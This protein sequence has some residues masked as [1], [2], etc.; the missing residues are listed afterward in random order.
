MWLI[1][2]LGNPGSKYLLTRHN[3]GFMA[4]DYLCQGAG[5]PSENGKVEHKAMTIDFKWDSEPVKLVKPQTYMNLSGESVSALLQYYKIPIEKL[6]VIHDDLDQPFGQIRIKSQSGD[7]GHNGLKSLIET[8]GTNNFLRVKI[9]IGRPQD[10]RFEIADYV[11]QKFSKTESE[12][13]PDVLNE[14][15]DAIECVIF[16]GPINAMNRFNV[17]KKE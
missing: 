6:L 17:R 11:L 13:L 9:G 5:V 7:G 16:D 12:V 3:V 4:L 1:V 10:P 8:L 14:A 2:G 15:V